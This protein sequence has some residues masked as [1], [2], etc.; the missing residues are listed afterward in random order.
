MSN[1]ADGQVSALDEALTVGRPES[2]STL[3]AQSAGEYDM[4]LGEDMPTTYSSLPPSPRASEFSRRPL[5][6]SELQ[7]AFNRKDPSPRRPFASLSDGESDTQEFWPAR[8]RRQTLDY[9][10]HRPSLDGLQARRHTLSRTSSN[11]TR[12]DPPKETTRLETELEVEE[13]STPVD[14]DSTPPNRA[15]ETKPGLSL[16]DLLR[17]EDAAEQWE[18]WIADGKWERIAN[19]LA[20]PL[21]VEKVSEDDV[22]DLT[23]R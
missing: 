17:D 14:E 3:T 6:I 8:S 18:G 16:W 23:T 15:K 1:V 22:V 20:V 9:A 21:G 4:D 12:H 10:N 19:F 11:T 2:A 13:P 7:S 5:D